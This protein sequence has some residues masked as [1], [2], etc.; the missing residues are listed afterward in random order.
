MMI[1]KLD[2]FYNGEESVRA[3]TER[4]EQK[5]VHTQDAK[6]RKVHELKMRYKEL[7]DKEDD[8]H[9]DDHKSKHSSD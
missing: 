3:Q 4:L 8:T 6:A 5:R 1:D 9:T 7:L 2:D